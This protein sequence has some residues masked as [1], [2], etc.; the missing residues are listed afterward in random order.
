MRALAKHL[1]IPFEPKMV[2]RKQSQKV[3]GGKSGFRPELSNYA[4]LVVTRRG[5]SANGGGTR[6]KIQLIHFYDLVAKAPPLRIQH[7]RAALD[8][9][10]NQAF[11][12][13]A[14]RESLV[15]L[16]R[17]RAQPRRADAGR[18]RKLGQG[19]AGRLRKSIALRLRCGHSWQSV[20]REFGV[21]GKLKRH[22][23]HVDE[24]REALASK[25]R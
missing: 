18:A 12:C 6:L 8:S 3:S 2:E 7:D 13:V 21:K 24:S 25:A 4:G 10:R 16:A 14:P 5:S 15:G 1:G 22:T 19:G 20:D 11:V 9:M 23:N 17:S